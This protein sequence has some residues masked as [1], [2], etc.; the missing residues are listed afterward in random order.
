MVLKVELPICPV[1]G[2][3]WLGGEE[4]LPCARA[5]EEVVEGRVG[6]CAV[7]PSTT[8]C[9]A[10]AMGCPIEFGVFVLDCGCLR[11]ERKLAAGD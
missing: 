11:F 9:P 6:R 2:K 10:V 7:I 8:N 1:R 4:V 3:G 5:E